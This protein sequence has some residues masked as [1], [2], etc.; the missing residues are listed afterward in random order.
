[1]SIISNKGENITKA[2]NVLYKT[3]EN[4]ELLFSDMDKEAEQMGFVSHT[5]K[6]MRWKSD[7]NF[8][9]WLTSSFI[10][11]Y[12]VEGERGSEQ[13]EE[14]RQGDIYAVEINLEE[15][16][17]QIWLCRHRFDFSVWK[18]M[19]ATADHWLFYQPLYLDNESLF[20]L[21][22]KDEFWYSMPTAKAQKSYWGIQGS[23][24]VSV[25]LVTVHSAE[26]IRAEIFDRLRTLP[27]PCK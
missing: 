4:L 14:L 24:A 22:E 12:Q 20:K 7:A 26:T 19:P 8:N 3:Y 13:L 10:K 18:R 21:V 17:P 2:L 25:P 16:Y 5:D 27:E 23:V 11:L 1:M 9:G 15:E 6:F